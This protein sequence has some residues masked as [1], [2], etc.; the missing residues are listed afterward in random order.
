MVPISS[1][2]LTTISIYVTFLLKSHV[3]ECNT[4]NEGNVKDNRVFAV[5]KLITQSLVVMFQYR[6]NVFD[7]L[8]M[9]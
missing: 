7:D 9:S 5:T 1:T 6:L 2:S 3:I 4:L 8:F